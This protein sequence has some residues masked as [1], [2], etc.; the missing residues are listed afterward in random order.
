MPSAPR[1]HSR[2]SVSVV[3]SSQRDDHRHTLLWLMAFLMLSSALAAAEI[4]SE[5]LT[6]GAVSQ[7][8]EAASAIPPELV[9]TSQSAADAAPVGPFVLNK[10]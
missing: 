7:P 10:D 3:A 8:L 1:F 4:R 5:V 9:V 6:L 2:R